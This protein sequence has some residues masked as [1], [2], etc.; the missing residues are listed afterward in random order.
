MSG[1]PFEIEFPSYLDGYEFE[2][3][4]KGYLVDLVVRSGDRVWNLTV[5][6]AVRLQQE[7]SDEVRSSGYTTL[8]NILVVPQITRTAITSAV[9]KLAKS[10][11]VEL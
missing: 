1:A 3:E 8:S 10:N 7:V 2:T 4:S 6:D 5:Y 9:S 11:F